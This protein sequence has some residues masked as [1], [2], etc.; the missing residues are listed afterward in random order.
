MMQVVKKAQVGERH[1]QHHGVRA[2]GVLRLS[3]PG[4]GH[5]LAGDHA[6]DGLPGGIRRHAFG[7]A[8]GRAGHPHRWPVASSCR[9]WRARPVAAG[10]AG[11]FMEDAPRSR[12]SLSD[13]P[14]AWPAAA[15][16]GV[17]ETLV[18]LGRRG[19]SS[20]ENSP[21]R[22]SC[23][24]SSILVLIKLKPGVTRADP[25]VP[26]WGSEARGLEQKCPASCARVRIQLHRPARSLTI[27][28][29][30]HAFDTG[31]SAGVRTASGAPG[32]R[33]V[34]LREIAEMDHL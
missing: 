10:V 13:G 25:R 22:S 24:C 33:P 29:I 15:H 3:Q 20:E 8:A 1:R 2:R 23:R 5:A 32:G 19:G 18:E 27:S 4:L 28:G 34:M 12:K 30:Q 21:S 17:L 26:A 16:A 9:C 6:G 11:I 7:A 31:E 14:N